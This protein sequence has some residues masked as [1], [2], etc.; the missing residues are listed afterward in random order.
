MSDYYARKLAGARL[1][2]CYELASPRVQLYLEAELR[3]VLARLAPTDRVLELGS[4]YGRVALRLARAARR[5]VGVDTA[6]ESLRLARA[7]PEL[8]PG[9]AY[10]AADARALAFADAA[11]DV[12]VCIQNGVCAFGID[13]PT[14]LGEALR[15]T[16]PGGRLLL[17]S[18]AD[19][20]WPERLAWFEAQAAAGLVGPLDR[21]AS[22][23]GV[24]ACQDGFRSG[25]M[26]PQDFRALCAGAGVACEV[27]TVDESSVFCEV[28]VP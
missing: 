12:V 15:V 3:H 18:Y 11:F 20:F 27:V 10:V 22:R 19:A 2:R 25:R 28:R 26:S 17:S 8:A 23:D 9:C 5:V 1:R 13:P 7:S 21:E 16:R 14:L 6:R 4:G 24:I